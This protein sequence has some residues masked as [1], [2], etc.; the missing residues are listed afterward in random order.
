MKTI[1]RNLLSIVR[2]FRV[3]TVLNVFG[4]SFAF[5]AF[6]TI[7][8]QVD[9]ERNFDRCHPEAEHIF[10][11]DLSQP[12][13]FS[14]VLP[15]AFVEAVIASSPH[16][17]AG[18]LINPFV[19]EVYFTVVGNDG[20]RHGFRE[21][22]QTCHPTLVRT[23]NFPIT[24]GDTDCLRSPD[25]VLIPES[26]ARRLFGSVSAVGRPLRAE[27]SIWSKSRDDDSTQLE[28]TVGAV[29]RDFPGNT[30]LRNV[31]YTAI[32]GAFLKENYDASNFIC[33]VRLDN[34]ASAVDVEENFNRHFNFSQIGHPGEQMKLTPLTSIYFMNESGDGHLFRSGN[35]DV[36]NLLMGIALLILVIAAVNYTNFS[37]AM[38]PLRMKSINTQ[39]VLGSTN[40]ALRLSLLIEACAICLTA[41]LLAVILVWG[42]HQSRLLAFVEADTSPLHHPV[43]LLVTAIVS[44]LVGLAAGVYPAYYMTS[45]P[46]AMVLKGSFGLSPRG[47]R[48]RLMLVSLQFVI[49]MTLIIGAGFV[50]LQNR[51]LRTHTIGFDRDQIAVVELNGAIAG[52]HAREY[53]DGLKSYAGIEDVAFASEKIGAK[54]VYMTESSDYN[55]R[56]FSYNLIYVSWNFLRTMGIHI[57]DGR[58][59][60]EA[61]ARSDRP[62]FI[63][64]D[65]ARR[66]LQMSV[67]PFKYWR[68]N[69]GDLVGFTGDLHIASLRQESTN[70]CLAA[71]PLGS[72]LSVSYIR[73]KSGT[74][75]RAATAHIRKTVAAIDPSFPI[76]ITFYDTIYNELYHRET[77]LRTLITFFG[78]L[79]VLLSLVGVFGLVVFDS[80][81]RR[82]EI[83]LRKVF[84][85]STG[86]I[87]ILF[88][89]SYLRIVAICF[90]VASPVAYYGVT[91]WLEHF[92]YRTP[93][94]WWVFAIAFVAVSAITFITVTFQN[95]RSANA[96]PV[97]SLKSE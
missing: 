35:A 93:I 66:S 63:F 26:M 24:E 16:I 32:D 21:T 40:S 87:L 6:M 73:L 50:Q 72:R 79:A 56:N 97:N 2:R 53:V 11:V 20:T 46:P 36:V 10:R 78:L 61:D 80:E 7:L 69:S 81:Y 89:R 58:D 62:A 90:V 33:Y 83:G 82:K 91:K 28:L 84:G 57:V 85:S 8:M 23:F 5:A 86:Q 71:S 59:F 45:F 49:S 44:L 95:W 76:D 12:G 43:L 88:N 47:R 19:G 60:T 15:R 27:E 30:Q 4:L 75:V 37:T 92:A 25:K 31:I 22:V 67:G 51:F 39:K 1:Y 41:F 65:H 52:H 77:T 96:N 48:L 54:D 13:E 70:I 94:R 14:T 55:G 74:D 64:N 18:T 17:E 38:T 34:A 68:D 29:Y 3:A 42:M 9:Y